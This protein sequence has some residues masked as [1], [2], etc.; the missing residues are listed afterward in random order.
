M[1][2]ALRELHESGAVPRVHGNGFIQLD[3]D[4]RR[5]LHIWGHRAIPKQKVASPIHDHIFGFESEIVV[6]RLLNVNYDFIPW[7]DDD[8][9]GPYRVFE[10]TVREGEDTVLNF[11]GEFCDVMISDC[12]L[13]DADTSNQN[14]FMQPFVF[15]ETFTS[16]PAATIIEKDGLTHAQ[17][18]ARFGVEESA[19]PRVLL[20]QGHEPDNDFNRYEAMPPWLAWAVIKDVLGEHCDL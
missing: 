2:I 5:R 18:A 12:Q 10:P 15:H 19:K 11:N 20:P 1:F 4:D 8:E 14:Y 6:G 16:G 3:L 7:N 13:I 17:R 9:S